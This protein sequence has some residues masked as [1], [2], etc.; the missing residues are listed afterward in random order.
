[1]PQSKQQLRSIIAAKR[2][3]LDAQWLKE[4]SESVAEHLSTLKAFEAAKRVALYKAIGGEV[5]LESLFARCWAM[6]KK[7]CIPVFNAEL[8]LYEMAEITAATEYVTGHYGIQE[9]VHPS[10][11]PLDSIDL[12]AVPGVAFDAAGNRLGR[13]G[14]YY[15]RLLD[16]FAGFSVAVAFD[17]QLFPHVPRDAHDIPVDCVITPTKII[18]V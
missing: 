10:L 18:P 9:P 7:T 11:I 15:D 14:G 2:K 3:A 8:K 16:G 13:G 5:D 4:N 6:G 12:I 17:F 1:M